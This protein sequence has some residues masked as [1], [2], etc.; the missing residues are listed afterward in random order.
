MASK[1]VEKECA[2]R[3]AVRADMEA[4]AGG[5]GAVLWTYER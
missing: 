2:E 3:A 4:R 1:A 5:R